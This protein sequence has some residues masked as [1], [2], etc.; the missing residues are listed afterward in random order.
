MAAVLLRFQHRFTL[1][2]VVQTLDTAHSLHLF[3]HFTR[4]EGGLKSALSID[5]WGWINEI[6]IVDASIYG[7]GTSWDF[8]R[9]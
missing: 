7:F 2:I 3:M 4:I 8:V 5:R 1:R 9:M 6:N